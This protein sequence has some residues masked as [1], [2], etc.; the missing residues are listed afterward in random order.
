VISKLGIDLPV[1][2]QTTTYPACN[3]A[4]YLTSL[5]Q[6]GQGGATYLYAHARRGMFLPLL[7]QSKVNNGAGMV[8]MNVVVYTGESLQFTYRVTQVRRHVTSLAAAYS[9]RG[10]S[11]WLQTSE[12]PGAAYPKLQLVAALVSRVAADVE[13]AHPDAYPV[14]C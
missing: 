6:P 11:L 1:M 9:W 14:R 2:R 12:G 4:M 7:T 3:V 5:K 13:S 10:E 8:G